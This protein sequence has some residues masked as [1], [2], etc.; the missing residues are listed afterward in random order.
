MRIVR[1]NS[2]QFVKY[3]AKLALVHYRWLAL[4]APER[5]E[6]DGAEHDTDA[7]QADP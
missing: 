7:E 6:G 2:I 5:D 3:V 4:G 1:A